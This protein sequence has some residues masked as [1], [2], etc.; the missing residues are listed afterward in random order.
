MK[1]ITLKKLGIIIL[2]IGFFVVVVIVIIWEI[3]SPSFLTILS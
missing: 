2:E 3:L 1:N